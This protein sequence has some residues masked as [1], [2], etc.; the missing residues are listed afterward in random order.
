MTDT[1]RL[2]QW[3]E[4]MRR[5][6]DERWDEHAIRYLYPGISRAMAARRLDASDIIRYLTDSIRDYCD[7]HHRDEFRESVHVPEYLRAIVPDRRIRA[8]ALGIYETA[9]SM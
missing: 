1:V 7:K 5:L 9:V 8:E 4:M 2:P 6:E 3:A